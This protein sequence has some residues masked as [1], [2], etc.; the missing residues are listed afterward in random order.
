[1][2]HQQEWSRWTPA[3]CSKCCWEQWGNLW[4]VLIKA[5]KTLDKCFALKWNQP[6]NPYALSLCSLFTAVRADGSEDANVASCFKTSR[7]VCTCTHRPRHHGTIWCC[8]LTFETSS[9]RNIYAYFRCLICLTSNENYYHTQKSVFTSG[10]IQSLVLRVSYNLN[11]L[12]TQETFSL[13]ATLLT[14]REAV[15]HGSLLL[16]LPSFSSTHTCR[17][18]PL[19]S[20][21]TPRWL[22][23]RH[24]VLAVQD[25][26][27]EDFL[28]QG[29]E[30]RNFIGLV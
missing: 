15:N 20:Y 11:V 18:T 8:L 30:G 3:T 28:T 24:N 25:P 29:V 26:G 19:D 4:N 1:M 17:I 9:Y 6:C 5:C 23:A 10:L 27:K 12:H 21:Q 13:E 16:F 14:S 22:Q 2:T 7:P